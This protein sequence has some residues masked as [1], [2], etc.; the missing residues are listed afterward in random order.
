[1]DELLSDAEASLAA[2]LADHPLAD[3]V[4]QAERLAA[5]IEQAVWRAT[6]GRVKDLR[7]EV[8]HDGILLTGHCNT[9]YAKQQAQHAA[10]RFPGDRS[11]INRIEVV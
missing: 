2:E 5:S 6:S 11:L 7:V 3:D 9:Y 8:N 10:M 4:C 1:M